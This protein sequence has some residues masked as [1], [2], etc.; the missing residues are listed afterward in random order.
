ME[1]VA[2]APEPALL[3]RYRAAL[4]TA[5]RIA[6]TRNVKP[7]RGKSVVFVDVSGSMQCAASGGAGGLGSVR[8]CADI[9][10]LMGLMLKYVCQ[11]CDLRIFS[12]P[13]G[14]G[15]GHGHGHGGAGSRKCHLPVHLD[16]DG[17]LSNFGK[18]RAARAGLGGGTDF[19]FDYLED[20][21][22][23]KSPDGG[24]LGGGGGA[25]PRIDNFFILSDM[26]IAPGRM[27]MGGPGA[28]GYSATSGSAAAR[29]GGVSGVL[30]EFRRA[31]NPDLLFVSVDLK[32]QCG[33]STVELED[34]APGAHPNDV[35]VTGYSD[36]IL[37]YVVERKGAQ[38]AYVDRIDAEKGLA[39]ATVAEGAAPGAE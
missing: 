31:V 29:A 7:I 35:L 5:I 10:I 6:T 28:G 32:G 9:A 30:R 21:I 17:I 38:A 1:V 18:V 4:E 13:G 25:P 39:A 26:M 33:R 36:E 16:G 8:T 2:A 27:E 37:R 22:A 3:R 24:V 14:Y 19:P 12:S 20:M 15:Y 34:G 23:G 11:E